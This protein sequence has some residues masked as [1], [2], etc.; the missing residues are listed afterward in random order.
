MNKV[1]RVVFAIVAND[2]GQFS[3]WPTHRRL[4][5][6]WSYIGPTGTRAEMHAWIREQFVET[7]PATYISRESRQ[8]ALSTVD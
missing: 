1:E 6:G 2:D 5:L 8:Q 7:V 4:P 3:V